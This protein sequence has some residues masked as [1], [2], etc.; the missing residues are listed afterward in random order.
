MATLVLDFA[1]DADRIQSS[2]SKDFH[3]YLFS[4]NLCKYW[5]FNP[6][7][8]T[9][10]PLLLEKNKR[11]YVDYLEQQ[12]KIE[13]E[14]KIAAAIAEENRRVAIERQKQLDEEKI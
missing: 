2:K 5:I 9:L 4:E 13:E 8:D 14:R 10:Y 7:K 11:D 1:D 12:K 6:L 3:K